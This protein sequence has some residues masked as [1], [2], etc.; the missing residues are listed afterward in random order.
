MG[1]CYNNRPKKQNDNYTNNNTT[2]SNTSGVFNE[3]INSK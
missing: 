2:T 1:I 3:N